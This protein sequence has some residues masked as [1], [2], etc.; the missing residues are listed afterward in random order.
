MPLRR[1]PW[2][3]ALRLAGAELRGRNAVRRG[4][5]AGSQWAAALLRLEEVSAVTFNSLLSKEL[6]W[7]SNLRRL[8]DLRRSASRLEKACFRAPAGPQ[9]LGKGLKRGATC[10]GAA[11]DG[12][13]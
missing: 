4:L 1:L 5:V 3:A 13:P 12:A 2:P 9:G 8:E 11:C 6:E 7:P 10:R